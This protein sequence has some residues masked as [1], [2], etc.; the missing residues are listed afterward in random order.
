MFSRPSYKSRIISSHLWRQ[1]RARMAIANA[2]ARDARK[3]PASAF[4]QHG[5]HQGTTPA[6][7][8]TGRPATLQ[9]RTRN[10]AGYSW[11]M[12]LLSRVVPISDRCPDSGLVRTPAR[13]ETGN[14]GPAPDVHGATAVRERSS[15]FAR[16]V[17]LRDVTVTSPVANA[18]P[19]E[20][21]FNG[22]SP[23][24]HRDQPLPRA[25]THQS[26][27]KP[28]RSPLSTNLPKEGETR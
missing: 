5:W 9:Q 2:T 21:V 3:Q 14:T 7:K 10:P 17:T 20:Q 15:A 23:V 24:N 1:H 8:R 16:N 12:W 26:A 25:L 28:L 27:T 11:V 13:T 19:V 18:T 22:C 6:I 4:S